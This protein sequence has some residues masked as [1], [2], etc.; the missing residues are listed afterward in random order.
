MPI[1]RPLTEEH[2]K[3]ISATLTGRKLSQETRQRMSDAKAGKGKSAEH[4]RKLRIAKAKKRIVKLE[5]LLAETR[6]IANGN[7]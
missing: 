6:E 1:Y 5:Q 4:I 3:K 7:F 2:K